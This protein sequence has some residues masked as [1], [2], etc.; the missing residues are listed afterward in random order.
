M[1]NDMN[2]LDGMGRTMWGMS[3]ISLLALVVLVLVAAA[4]LKY[5]HDGNRR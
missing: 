3:A 1:M 2:S 5:L 4:L